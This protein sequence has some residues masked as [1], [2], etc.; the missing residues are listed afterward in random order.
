MKAIQINNKAPQLVNL[1]EPKSNGVKVKIRVASICSSDLHLMIN[2]WAENRV[3]GHEFAGY[4][5]DGTAVAIEPIIACG[6]CGY[7]DEGYHNHCSQQAQLLGVG[8]DGGMAE[9]IIVPP[10]IL[11]PIPTGLAIDIS[12]SFKITIILVFEAPALFIAS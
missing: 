11:I 1:P 8:L 7:C 10:N 3:L 12:L 6:S 4:T 5:D 9:S 2:G